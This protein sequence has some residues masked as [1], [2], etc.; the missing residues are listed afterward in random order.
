MDP[1]ADRI[2]LTLQITWRA[3]IS[4]TNVN[5]IEEYTLGAGLSSLRNQLFLHR[6]PLSEERTTVLPGGLDLSILADELGFSHVRT[7]EHYFR[8]YGGMTPNPIVFL[9]MVAAR[10]RR[11]RLESWRL[12]KRRSG[13]E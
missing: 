1:W 11:V 3:I 7:V 4:W 6:P 2:G 12:S 5:P 13:V 8:P 10:T 9:T